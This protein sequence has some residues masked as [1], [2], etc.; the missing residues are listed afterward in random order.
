LFAFDVAN[1]VY[2]PSPFISSTLLGVA[3]PAVTA[4]RA[5]PFNALPLLACVGLRSL[6][7]GDAFGTGNDGDVGEDVDEG[8]RRGAE[9]GAVGAGGAADGKVGLG[10]AGLGGAGPGRGIGKFGVYGDAG[11]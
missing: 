2:R 10:N 4:E 1:A 6:A 7:A 11:E 5:S 8:T 3:G 9:A